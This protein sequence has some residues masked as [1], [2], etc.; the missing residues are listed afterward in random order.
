MMWPLCKMQSNFTCDFECY[1]CDWILPTYCFSCGQ[2]Y[3]DGNICN[4]V[5]PMRLYI[6]VCFQKW[7]TISY[8]VVY[9]WLQVWPSFT[10]TCVFDLVLP[11]CLTQFYLCVWPCVSWGDPCCRTSCHSAHTGT[12]PTRPPLGG[13]RTWRVSSECPTIK[14]HATVYKDL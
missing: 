3:L 11:V 8:V 14:F 1:T 7:H 10:N 5:L 13:G 9:V 4:Q 2:F 6:S 12:P